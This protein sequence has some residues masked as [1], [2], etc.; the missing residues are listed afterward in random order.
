MANGRQKCNMA[1]DPCPQC[2]CP[3]SPCTLW[4]LAGPHFFSSIEYSRVDE[5]QTVT[6][7]IRLHYFRLYL[8]LRLLLLFPTFEYWIPK[9]WVMVLS[10]FKNDIFLE[11]FLYFYFTYFSLPKWFLNVLVDL[12]TIFMLKHT[13]LIPLGTTTLLRSR[14]TYPQLI[15][16]VECHTVT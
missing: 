9:V 5:I 12:N 14:L 13:R 2:S 8:I 6:S 7:L 11:L 16:L 1:Q 4:V 3:E 15:L 10:L